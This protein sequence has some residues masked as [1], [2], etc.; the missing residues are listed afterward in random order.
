M[1]SLKVKGRTF[2]YGPHTSV[3]PPALGSAA[4]SA[5]WGKQLK[6]HGL[7][8]DQDFFSMAADLRALNENLAYPSELTIEPVCDMETLEQWVKAALIGFGLSENSENDCLDLFAALGFD[9]PLRNY[10]GLM[11]GR[12]V[13]TSQ[14]FLA[15]GV[16]GVYWVSTVPEAR[17]QGIGMALTLALLREARAMGYRISILHPS[18]MGRG[19]YRRLGFED[20]GKLSYGIWTGE[21]Q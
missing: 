2:K 11:D 12:P 15:A 18:D 19:V 6:A 1:R 20:Y 10:V 13:A 4:Q 17:R 14:L 9:M 8:Y 16:A 3:I 5:D 21:I 7:V